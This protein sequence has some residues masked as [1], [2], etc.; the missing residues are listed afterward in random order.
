ML[1][2]WL[3]VTVKLPARP[4]GAHSANVPLF[5][6]PIPFV[7]GSTG[8]RARRI[9]D[10]GHDLV[11]GHATIEQGGRHR[12]LC[13]MDRGVALA[14]KPHAGKSCAYVHRGPAARNV[15]AQE[16]IAV[17]S[18]TLAR[19]KRPGPGDPFGEV[20]QLVS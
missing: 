9:E 7:P 12:D 10:R 18:R 13:L 17:W 1:G 3:L 4:R 5:V 14:L 19:D 2:R 6:R 20:V 16:R 15:D 11:D 8:G